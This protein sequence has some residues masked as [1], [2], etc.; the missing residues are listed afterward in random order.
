M[1]RREG[2]AEDEKITKRCTGIKQHR[3]GGDQGHHQLF[4]M[5]IQARRD[6]SPY[7][8]KDP[9]ERAGNSSHDGHLDGHQKGRDHAHRNHFGPF[10]Q[11]FD[12]GHGQVVVHLGRARINDQHGK[13]CRD[14][15]DGAQQ[16]VA[17]FKQVLDKRLLRACEFVVFGAGVVHVFALGGRKRATRAAPDKAL[18]RTPAR[19]LYQL[20]V[21][22]TLARQRFL[23]GWPIE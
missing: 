10:R 16:A 22:L 13:H 20:G 14:T 4:F 7:L 21:A 5:L 3:A 6:K 23:G 2:L 1:D 12:Q 18:V 17:Q 15:V 11:R 19:A 8:V 9:G